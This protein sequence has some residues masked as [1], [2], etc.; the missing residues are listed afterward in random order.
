[1]IVS[2]VLG[3]SL[4]ISPGLDHVAALPWLE[5]PRKPQLHITDCGYQ[6]GCLIVSTSVSYPSISWTGFFKWQLQV[7]DP[8]RQETV[9]VPFKPLLA[10]SLL[11]PP[12]AKDSNVLKPL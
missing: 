12:L 7:S 5:G 2:V 6:L 3:G 11:M 8:R 10:R 9:Q 1:M 4:L